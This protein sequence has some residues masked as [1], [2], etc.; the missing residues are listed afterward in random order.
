[1]IQEIF[2]FVDGQPRPKQ[3]FKIGRSGG[4]I[5]GFT[6]ARVKSW[7]QDVAWAALGHM[8]G[9]KIDKPLEG[10]LLVRLTF[11]LGDARRQDSDNLSKAVLDALNGT[12][13]EDDR[14]VVDLIIAKYI[15][16]DRQG[17]L[18]RVETT[19]RRMELSLDEINIIRAGATA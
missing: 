9:R 4:R 8:R 13:W 10:N 19:P 11:Y 5:T 6:P 12:V 3:S 18:V 15:C 2:F 14:Q 1:M 17:V 16:R 7:Q